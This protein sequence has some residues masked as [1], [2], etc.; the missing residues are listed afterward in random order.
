MPFCVLFGGILCAFGDRTAKAV[1]RRK[2]I[3]KGE[4]DSQAKGAKQKICQIRHRMFSSR[5]VCCSAFMLL[6]ICRVFLQMS[7][8]FHF[9]WS[10]QSWKRTSHPGEPRDKSLVLRCSIGLRPSVCHPRGAGTAHKASSFGEENEACLMFRVVQKR[11]IYC[12]E[13]G[14]GGGSPKY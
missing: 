3:P 6:Q 14:V 5:L 10:H 12:L 1:P 4:A 2:G 11:N 8:S 9:V 7:V 13:P